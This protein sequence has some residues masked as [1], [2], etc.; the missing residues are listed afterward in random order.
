MKHRVETAQS[1]MGMGSLKSP[2][3]GGGRRGPWAPDAPSGSRW[4]SLRARVKATR[5]IRPMTSE[6]PM[7]EKLSQ[8][9]MVLLME[10]G[11]VLIPGAQLCNRPK[12]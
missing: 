2:R 5:P 10:V 1:A 3:S 8:K 12:W 9:S 6:V 7:E 11:M 4:S